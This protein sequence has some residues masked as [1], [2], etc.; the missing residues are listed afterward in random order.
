MSIVTKILANAV[1]SCDSYLE[2][3]SFRFS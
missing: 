2:G 1:G 3:P